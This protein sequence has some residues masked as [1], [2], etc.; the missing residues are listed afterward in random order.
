MSSLGVGVH[1]PEG[2]PLFYS[3]NADDDGRMCLAAKFK[4]PYFIPDSRE[5]LRLDYSL[6]HKSDARE[7]Q[8][9]NSIGF[10]LPKRMPQ[11]EPKHQ[12]KVPFENDT[13]KNFLF[14]TFWAAFWAIFAT[15]AP[16]L[17]Q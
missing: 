13:Y 1:V 2:V 11:C 15:V 10:I 9:G 7:M 3:W 16:F 5:P 4:A 17:I 8:G 6:C 14:W 12:P